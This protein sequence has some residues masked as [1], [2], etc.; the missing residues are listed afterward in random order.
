MKPTLF[1]SS[2]LGAWLVL[3]PAQPQAPVSSFEFIVI[4]DTRPTFES[5]NFR[6]FEGIIPKINAVRPA[7]T[8]NLGD[9]IYG[10]GIRSKERQW[11]KYQQ[12]AS[13]IA[14]PYHQ[15]PGNHDTFS[16]DARRVYAQRF[17]KFYSSFDYGGSHFVLLDN[18]EDGKWG[19]IGPLEMEWLKRD[20]GATRAAS[21]FVFMHFPTWEQDRVV[22][23]YHVLWR[24][25]LQ[26][27]FRQSRVKAVFGGH[28]HCYGPTR[29]FDGIRYFITGGGGAELRPDYREAGG[30]HHFVKVR[31]SGDRFDVRV[32]TDRGEVKDVDADLMGGFL[33]AEKNTSRIGIVQGTQDLK[34][35]VRFGV[36]INNP[37][38]EP[39]AGTARWNV[40]PNQF[41]IAPREYRVLVPAGGTSRLAFQVRAPRGGASALAAMPWLRFD[42]AAGG[43]RHRFHRVLLFLQSLSAGFRAK[44]PVLDGALA[45]WA[46]APTLRVGAGA[47]AAVVRASHGRD[48]LYLAIDVPASDEPLSDDSVFSDELQVG[49]APRAGATD[50]GGETLRVG[51]EASGGTTTVGDRTP[52][53]LFGAP[54]PTVKAV[55]R[56]DG[57][58][59]TFEMLIP[60]RLLGPAGAG[61]TTSVVMSLSY[62]MPAGA[63]APAE[64]SEP[65]PNSLSY[66]VRYG[67]DVLV[68]VHFVELVLGQRR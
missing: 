63:A 21:V 64:G 51:V 60:T 34:Q 57:S 20:L 25:T 15:V 31:V 41:A 53:H 17:G 40:D 16:K 13:R 48:T 4:G 42:L 58:R 56:R 12:V 9:L 35:G 24:D 2:L 10:Y 23:K 32:M 22:P 6:V 18:G 11:D 1:A 8:V 52:G 37:Y 59:R 28:F 7:F 55:S 5:E 65:S 46:G 61:G 38:D 30:Q 26:P 47:A 50:F 45:D 43:V 39:L 19:E 62:P 66:Q 27:L 3:A 33:F 29:E 36:R 54:L 67:G 68:P 49:F 14:G 44:P